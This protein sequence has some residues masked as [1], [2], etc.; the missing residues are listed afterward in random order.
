MWDRETVTRSV[1]TTRRW[2]I[3]A[4]LKRTL[5]TLVSVGKDKTKGGKVKG[6]THIRRRW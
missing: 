1:Q 5:L 4:A 6:S 2:V 3:I